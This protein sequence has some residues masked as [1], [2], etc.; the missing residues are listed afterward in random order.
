MKKKMWELKKT[1]ISVKD[2][3]L[4]VWY[5]NCIL[6]SIWDLS[7]LIIILIID[8]KLFDR[9]KEKNGSTWSNRAW[10]NFSD[11]N[12][13]DKTRTGTSGNVGGEERRE[14]RSS[15]EISNSWMGFFCKP[16]TTIKEQF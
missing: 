7:F 3:T 13:G 4:N 14:F 15:R 9:K 1:F 12:G 2:W 16:F 6:S 11:S 10:I 5:F 8:Y